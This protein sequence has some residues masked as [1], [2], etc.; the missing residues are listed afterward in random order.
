[1]A[2]SRYNQD[3]FRRLDVELIAGTVVKLEVL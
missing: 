3:E 1:M 2:A